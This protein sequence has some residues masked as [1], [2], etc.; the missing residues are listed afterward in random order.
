MLRTE[1]DRL[2]GTEQGRLTAP[3]GWIAPEGVALFVLGCDVPGRR[4]AFVAGDRA[5]IHQTGDFGTGKI[6]RA[7]ARI[8]GPAVAPPGDLAWV[9]QLL[10]DNAVVSSRPIAPGTT[11]TLR[12]LGWG[13]G[14]LAG[15]H[16]VAFRLAL[17]G[18][19][20][21]PQEI[22]I[23]AFYVDAITLGA[24]VSPRPMLVNR[25]PERDETGVAPATM[26][27]L[28][29]VDPSGEG[30]S[31][32]K[33]KIYVGGVLAFNAGTFSAGFNGAGSAY[34]TPQADT[35][36]VRIDPTASFASEEAV[37]V[38]AISHHTG[39]AV[40]PDSD[41][42]Y[43]FTIADVTAP[44]I[45]SASAVAEKKIRIA[46]TE[47]MSFAGAGS[48][49]LAGDYSFERALGA[50]AVP[51]S[52]VSV[53]KVSESE[54]E[55]TL[56]TEIT[57]GVVYTVTITTAQ[58]ASGNAIAAPD[59][60]AS[61]AGYACPK[62]DDREWDLYRLLPEMNRAE[63]PGDLEKF[64]AIW[65]EIGDLLLCNIDRFPEIVDPDVA[66]IAFVE[67]MLDDLGNPFSFALSDVDK[68]RLAQVLVA[69]YKEK[70]TDRGTI[71]AIRF[72]LGFD[73]TIEVPGF[74]PLGLG[75]WELGIDW[76]LGSSLQADLYTFWLYP[77]FVLTEEERA[78]VREIADYMKPAH[79]HF[80]IIEPTPAPEIPDHLELGLSEL[81]VSW[82]LH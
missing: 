7:Q 6:L 37:T 29:L 74:A 36:R 1:F 52:S 40:T 16:K 9:A 15:N 63:D 69:I 46:F 64:I 50:I 68:R 53:E 38:R 35:L 11:R 22:E 10:I 81:G 79:T 18:T 24:S 73:V 75:D 13:V 51:V 25:S 61:F 20:V 56:D 23:P 47:D 77:G 57:P 54:V 71:N 76:I 80:A 41:T 70:G 60:V 66:P 45:L 44:R 67:A 14:T 43:T 19:V 30:V 31:L 59:N 32:A 33:T 5:E 2:F 28:D 27:D 65:Q 12:D 82:I 26:I 72:F 4:G 34:S 3:A 21:A 8:R 78:R 49:L 39:A 48:A 17:T 55:V 62:P 42:S 58:D